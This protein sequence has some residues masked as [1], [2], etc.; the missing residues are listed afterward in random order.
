MT[1]E[2]RDKIEKE[3]AIIKEKIK[4]AEKD[5]I[6]NEFLNKHTLKLIDKSKPF[7]KL[8]ILQLHRVS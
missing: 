2:M 4:K 7:S 8:M 5:R 3:E 6:K 1:K